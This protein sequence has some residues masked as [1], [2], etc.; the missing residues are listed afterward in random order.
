MKVSIITVCYNDLEGLKKTVHSV[1]SLSYADKELIVV[2][3]LSKDGSQDFIINNK[4]ID[5]KIIEADSGIYNA[6]N[7]GVN[8]ADGD[9]LIFMNAGDVFADSNALDDIDK[10]CEDIVYGSVYE[11]KAKENNLVR[12]LCIDYIWKGMIFS[13]QSVFIKKSLLELNPYNEKMKIA[14]DY[15]FFLKMY[16]KKRSFKEL[17]R[18]IS[19][20]DVDGVSRNYQV[21]STKER[22]ES[23]KKNKILCGKIYIYYKLLLPYIYIKS[24]VKCLIKKN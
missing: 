12:P 7:K 6:M 16:I 22:I 19:I 23:L 10:S 8:S 18:P 15:D 14:A 17:N 20:V 24:V 9:Y 13:H 1:E 3:G 2:D 5:K 11:G 4:V 21:L